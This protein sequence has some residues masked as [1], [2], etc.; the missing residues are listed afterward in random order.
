M[1]VPLLSTSAPLIIP[2]VAVIAVGGGALMSL[3]YALLQPLMP[4]ERHG[5]L[6]G[7]YSASR[8]VGVALG[9]LLGGVAISLLAGAFGS[10]DGYAAVWG[11]CG[12]AALMSLPLL[13]RVD[14]PDKQTS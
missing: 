8:G 14:E 4:E 2:A 9:P 13:A 5:A 7:F 1:I 3:P 10:T 11:V 12:V 6:T